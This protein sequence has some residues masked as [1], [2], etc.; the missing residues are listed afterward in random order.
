MPT[1]HVE[2]QEGWTGER[3]EIW[4]NGA[5]RYTGRPTTRLQ[6]GYADGVVVDVGSEVIALDVRLPELPIATTRSV[7]VTQE[8][9]IGLSRRNGR[10]RIVDQAAPFGYV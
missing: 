10:L 5:R 7:R 4:V 9:W 6:T 1:V 3:V 8:H 2:L